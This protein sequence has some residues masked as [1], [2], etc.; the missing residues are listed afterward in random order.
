MKSNMTTDDGLIVSEMLTIYHETSQTFF[1]LIEIHER[2]DHAFVISSTIGYDLYVHSLVTTFEKSAVIHCTYTCDIFFSFQCGE[3]MRISI[4][5]HSRK[6]TILLNGGTVI[7]T[8]VA[9]YLLI[10]PHTF[11]SKSDSIHCVLSLSSSILAIRSALLVPCIKREITTVLFPYFL[12][13]TVPPS[14]S[15]DAAEVTSAARLWRLHDWTATQTEAQQRL[16][17]LYQLKATP[18]SA[19]AAYAWSWLN[20]S[21]L[22]WELFIFMIL[23]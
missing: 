2:V 22:N 11:I 9:S 21:W 6:S 10:F 20:R 14:A 8:T 7:E 17:R 18:Y 13:M 3:V 15:D 1:M 16:M 12:S 19:A 4:S 23:I 5:I